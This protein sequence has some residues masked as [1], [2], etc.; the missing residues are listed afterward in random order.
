MPPSYESLRAEAVRKDLFARAYGFYAALF[1]F[2]LFGTVGSLYLITA[3][4][5]PYIQLANAVFLGFVL[6]QAGMLGHDFSHQQVFASR[7]WNRLGG[8]FMWGL[9]GGLSEDGW[10]EKHNAHHKYVNWV[11]HDP[12]V[13]I[14]FIFS[15]RQDLSAHRVTRLYV[16]YEHLVFFAVLP[17][18]YFS[19]LSW[20][21]SHLLR[22]RTWRTLLD[23]ALIAAHFAALLYVIFAHLP[24]PLG[25]A[26]LLIV[27]A[28]SGLYMSCVFAPN[29]KGKAVTG[30]GEIPTWLTQI[31]STRNVKPTRLSFFL[32]GG[33]N[34]QI[35]HHLFT[36]MAR[37]R[38]WQA[39]PLVRAYCAQH[40][41]PYHEVSWAQSM[42]QIHGALRDQAHTYRKRGLG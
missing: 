37:V 5:N 31:T 12:D 8:A 28:V 35:E 6:V 42:R 10:Y 25:I 9:F 40:A 41:I 23:L 16:T 1:L 17:L 32:T 7:A 13:D 21:W 33:L 38:Y 22:T 3:T 26:F 15:D 24:L 18:V 29:H 30:K 36:D 2:V 20:T 14:P 27:V 4:D 34:F 11:G 19:M 39:R